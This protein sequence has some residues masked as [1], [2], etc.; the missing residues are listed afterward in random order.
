MLRRLGLAVTPRFLWECLTSRIV[1][2]FPAPASSNPACRFPALG[3]PVGFASERLWPIQSGGLSA[4]GFACNS[5]VTKQSE[6]VVEPSPSPSLPA[7]S[8]ALSG[9][10]QMPPDLRLDPELNV[11]EAPARVPHRKVVHPTPQNR[12]DKVDHPSYRLADVSP[13]DFFKLLQQC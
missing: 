13:E 8:F 9:T 1:S 11:G 5:V 2:W 12:I 10:H 6:C 3:F 7:K 4:E